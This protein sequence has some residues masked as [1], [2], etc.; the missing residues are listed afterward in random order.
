MQCNPF[1]GPNQ[2]ICS[3]NLTQVLLSGP[4]LHQRRGTSVHL[5]VH[6]YDSAA[7][8]AAAAAAAPIAAASATAA[9]R[10]AAAA[11]A[12]TIAPRH[13]QHLTTY[14][15]ELAVSAHATQH[16]TLPALWQIVLLT[17]PRLTPPDRLRFVYLGVKVRQTQFCLERRARVCR[18]DA[19]ATIGASAVTCT[20]GSPVPHARDLLRR[21]VL[22][23]APGS[24]SDTSMVSRPTAD[25]P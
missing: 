1:L 24:C 20:D 8:A 17:F 3:D 12:A 16:A 4:L 18:A 21:S 6:I 10:A 22:P 15:W 5:V 9:P 7:A 11:T 25:A 23:P 14:T 13:M 2:R 19:D